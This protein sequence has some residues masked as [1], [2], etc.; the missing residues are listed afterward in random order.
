MQQSRSWEANSCSASQISLLL[1]NLKNHYCRKIPT[2][3]SIL[4]EIYRILITH[5]IDLWLIFILPS[6][7][8]PYL[9]I[10]FFS[11]PFYIQILY[12]VLICPMSVSWLRQ[13]SSDLIILI[14]FPQARVASPLGTQNINLNIFLSQIFSLRSS[15]NMRDTSQNN[16][17]SSFFSFNVSVSVY[18]DARRIIIK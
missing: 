10:C 1:R 18:K 4:I 2:L 9:L 13:N 5:A 8:K 3:V 17:R 15:C 6:Y 11:S 7:P 14:I 12:R 16:K